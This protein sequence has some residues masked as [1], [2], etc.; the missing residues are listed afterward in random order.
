VSGP[1]PATP[2]RTPEQWEKRI[3]KIR[4]AAN[5]PEG[6]LANMPEEML[7]DA[8]A[9]TMAFA[10]MTTKAA[11]YLLSQAPVNPYAHLPENL[12]PKWQ[13]SPGDLAKFESAAIGVEDPIAALERMQRG[14]TSPE[15]LKAIAAVYPRLWEDARNRLFDRVAT[16]KNLTYEQRLRLQPILGPMATGSTP[17]QAVYLQQMHDRQRVP[18]QVGG[19]SPDGRQ[20]V[21]TTKNLETQATRL[22]ARGVRTP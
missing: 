2:Q 17:E 14:Y 3:A 12:R 4:A 18:P 20:V 6:Y 21:S 19:A 15:T 1:V 7:R 5:N 13:P 16:A 22:E 10:S 8:P 11:Q 9:S